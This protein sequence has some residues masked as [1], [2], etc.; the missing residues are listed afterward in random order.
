LLDPSPKSILRHT[1]GQAPSVDDKP[2]S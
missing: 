2:L 1:Q